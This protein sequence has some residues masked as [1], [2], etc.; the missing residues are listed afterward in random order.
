MGNVPTRFTQVHTLSPHKDKNVCMCMGVG[1]CGCVWGCWCVG[2]CVWGVC[3]CVC[4]CWK[5]WTT[6]LKLLTMLS[7]LCTCLILTGL[8]WC[9]MRE[10]QNMIVLLEGKKIK[11]TLKITLHKKNLTG[12]TAGVYASKFCAIYHSHIFDNALW[13]GACMKD[14][15]R[16]LTQLQKYGATWLKVRALSAPVKM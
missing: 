1:L 14:V 10:W 15:C 6:P 3:V 4:V 2:V 7:F 11:P 9:M 5:Q 13:L 8:V 16:R 12:H